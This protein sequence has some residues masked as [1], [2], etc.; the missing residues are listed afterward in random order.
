MG[1]VDELEVFG[2]KTTAR[3]K[4][5]IELF[6]VQSFF[7]SEHTIIIQQSFGGVEAST[8]TLLHEATRIENPS[9][10]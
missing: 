6:S 10:S 2:V 4:K 5:T 8:K 7:L 9:R 3:R 1:G